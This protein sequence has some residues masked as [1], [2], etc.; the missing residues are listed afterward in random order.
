MEI[1]NRLLES[2]RTNWLNLSLNPEMVC[3]R[4]ASELEDLAVQT[5]GCAAL[6]L[7]AEKLTERAGFNSTD[8]HN[9]IATLKDII[10]AI[11]LRCDEA[12]RWRGVLPARRRTLREGWKFQEM[13]GAAN[14]DAVF[15]ELP[16]D[17]A[18]LERTL[19]AQLRNVE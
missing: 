15:Q 9:L 19:Q 6:A 2:F 10:L 13:V 3:A 14:S 4:T 17:L 1:L 12:R 16:R 8:L 7:A 11:E 18:L 5:K